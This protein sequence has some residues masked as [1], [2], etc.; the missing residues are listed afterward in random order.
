[1]LL[2]RHA[3][4]EWNL[5]FGRTRI[6]P[7][8]PDPVLTEEGQAQARAAARRLAGTRVARLICSPYRRCL[9]TASII[10][11]QVGAAIQVDPLVRERC[12]FSCDQGSAPAELGRLWPKLSFDHLEETWWGGLIESQAGIDARARAFRAREWP[13]HE[14]TVIVS[15]WGFLRALT[16]LEVQNSAFV[17]Y[18]PASGSASLEAELPV[19]AA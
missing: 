15:H 10:A 12:A 4:S 18:D 16:G 17:R 9:Q 19:P 3:Q 6:D 5:H 1:M 13:D 8:I 2:I 11:E 14:R 7:G